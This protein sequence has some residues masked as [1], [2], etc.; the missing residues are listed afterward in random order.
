VGGVLVLLTKYSALSMV[1]DRLEAYL[2]APALGR[3]GMVVA[4]VFFQYA[5]PEGLG[6]AMKDNAGWREV[7]LATLVTGAACWLAGAER[8]LLAMALAGGATWLAARFVLKRLPGLTGD[9]Y[10]A[11]CEM[12]EVMVLLIFTARAPA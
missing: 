9:I 3:W 7:A 4:I 6:R 12:L 8:G 2:L 10:G 11:I 1:Q 5:R